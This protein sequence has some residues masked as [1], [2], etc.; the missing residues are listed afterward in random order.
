MKKSGLKATPKLKRE[1]FR[2][3]QEFA[4]P[5]LFAAAAKVYLRDREPHWSKKTRVLHQNSLVHLA[6]YFAKRRLSDIRAEDIIRYQRSRLRKGASPRSVNVQ[7]SL[8]RL[9]MKKHN[10]WLPIADESRMLKEGPDAGRA[11]SPDEERRLL[12]AV[13]VSISRSLYPAVLLALH[14]GLWLSEIRLLR[15]RQVDLSDRF[16]RLGTSKGAGDEGPVVPLSD[17][18]VNCLR[19]WKANFPNAD[20]GDAVFPREAY[21][22]V[23]GDFTW[24]EVFPTQP[25]GTWNRTWKRAKAEANVEC[26][27]HDLRQTFVNRN[28]ERQ[29]NNGTIHTVP[30]WVS[31]RLIKKYWV[32]ELKP[33]GPPL[34]VR[35]L[36]REHQGNSDSAKPGR[37]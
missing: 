30:R 12:A 2:G 14:T 6:P 28:A 3:A 34:R 9:V 37:N 16:L 15:W 36:S 18:A 20:P 31:A 19:E 35:E 8:L 26:R 1:N 10:L 32:G 33:P 11:L 17:T 7:I 29:G 4:R 24:T 25:I 5:I 27:W 22:L 23:G 13:K 21:G